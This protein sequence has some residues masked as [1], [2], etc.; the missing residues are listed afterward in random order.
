MSL[1]EGLKTHLSPFLEWGYRE[2]TGHRRHSSCPSEPSACDEAPCGY[3]HKWPT[4]PATVSDSERSPR[5]VWP[6]A[7]RSRVARHQPRPKPREN[8]WLLGPER[9]RECSWNQPWL[10]FWG[11]SD[12]GKA[13]FGMSQ[14]LLLGPC[15][16]IMTEGGKVKG[17]ETTSWG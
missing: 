13:F 5:N 15:K 3:R 9:R 1:R 14:R 10:A 2:F 12:P 6:R 11:S 7:A 17:T 8:T 4:I 16:L